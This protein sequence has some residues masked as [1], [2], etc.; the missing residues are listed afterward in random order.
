VLIIFKR[1]KKKYY[2]WILQKKRGSYERIGKKRLKNTTKV[3]KY[4][5][6]PFS[7]NIELDTFTRGLKSFYW[8][9]YSSKKQILIDKHVAPTT[10]ADIYDMIHGIKI[11]K[12]LSANLGSSAWK[13]NLITLFVGIALGGG[14]GFIIA[15]YI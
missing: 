6:K 14:F 3:F 2:A 7:I 9:D 11:V 10:D 5:G 13:M 1:N 4:K 12:Q 15:G 8:F